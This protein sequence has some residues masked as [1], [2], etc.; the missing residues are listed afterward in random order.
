MWSGFAWLRIVTSGW[1]LWV[2]SEPLGPVCGRIFLDH[3]SQGTLPPCQIS[4]Q[5]FTSFGY[6]E[7]SSCGNKI[8]WLMTQDYLVKDTCFM[9]LDIDIVGEVPS[10]WIDVRWSMNGRWGR[11]IISHV[12]TH[13]DDVGGD[14]PRY[15]PWL[16][17][18]IILWTV[19]ITRAGTGQSVR[20]HSFPREMKNYFCGT[21]TEKG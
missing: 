6:Q 9:P 21:S 15:C 19:R 16:D 12:H 17:I 13:S 8:S 5:V 2:V 1:I 11:D 4:T 7:F 3:L 14:K 18:I 10:V 20:F